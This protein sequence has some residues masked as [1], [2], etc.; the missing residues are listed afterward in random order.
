[1][2]T[3]TA[4][5]GGR[6]LAA[7]HDAGMGTDHTAG[8]R[9]TGHGLYTEIR[10]DAGAP[11]L[12][13]LHGGPGQGCHDYMA[14]QGGL[15][16]RS[17]RLIGI[18]QRGV[19][20]SAPLPEDSGL[21]VADLVEDCEAAR[22]T[23][24]IERWAVAGQSFGG[25]LALRYAAAY[26]GRTTAVIFENPVWDMAASAHAALPAIAAMLAERG[27]TEAAQAAL[28]AAAGDRATKPQREAYL[29]A[30]RALGDDRESF[31]VPSAA[32]R[33]RLAQVR[34]AHERPDGSAGDEGSLRHHLAIVADPA[35]EE[36]IQHL[37]ADLQVPLLLIVG[38]HDPLTSPEQREAFRSAPHGQVLEVAAAG[39][40]VHA[41]DPLQY[42]SAVS[43]FVRVAAGDLS[44]TGTGQVPATGS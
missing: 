28:T 22:Q 19:D 23:L 44:G 26:P 20:R 21:T 4:N 42:A 2:A 7:R 16:G 37:L 30:L 25:R 36:P 35:S 24:G 13:F 3:L 27:N 39:H 12:L 11:A 18:D 5:T 31:F 15:L 34:Q 33:A 9:L 10:G 41:D 8:R 6:R 43:A 40:F 17:V 14:I 38:G 29:A 1:L 32:T